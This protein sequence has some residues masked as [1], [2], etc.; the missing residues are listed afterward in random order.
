MLYHVVGLLCLHPPLL[1]ITQVSTQQRTLQLP[2]EGWSTKVSIQSTNTHPPLPT[3]KPS[4]RCTTHPPIHTRSAIH[5]P[6]CT[7]S[8]THPPLLTHGRSTHRPVLKPRHDQLIPISSLHSTSLRRKISRTSYD[9]T[10]T[11]ACWMCGC[12]SGA[13]LLFWD[14]H[15]VP[16]N[17]RHPRPQ[18]NVRMQYG[19]ISQQDA[20][21][22]KKPCGRGVRRPLAKNAI[23]YV[24]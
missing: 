21:R 20:G 9:D 2:T 16:V 8:T 3:S 19:I 4:P 12:A 14:A 18:E 11:S 24:T 10:M 22:I 13:V 1:F 23:T 5:P 17:F 15:N 6:L 7:R